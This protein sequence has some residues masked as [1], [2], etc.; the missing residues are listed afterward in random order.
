MGIHI[1]YSFI[2]RSKE[3]AKVG[4][5]FS[6]RIFIAEPS[7]IDA[8]KVGSSATPRTKKLW[9]LEVRLFGSHGS[10]SLVQA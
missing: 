9:T 4:R 8:Y 3:H 10:L 2:A 1:R 6:K 7:E 5:D